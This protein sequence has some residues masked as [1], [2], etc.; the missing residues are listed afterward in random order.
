[1]TCAEAPPLLP[2]SKPDDVHDSKR[3]NEKR[4]STSGRSTPVLEYSTE[5]PSTW[6]SWVI[7]ISVL[8]AKSTY[9]RNN[10]ATT[11]PFTFITA[12]VEFT[13]ESINIYYPAVPSRYG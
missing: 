1:M 5:I 10:P 9:N 6:L 7:N 4:R 8:F 11:E 12:R 2:Q 3:S 13:T